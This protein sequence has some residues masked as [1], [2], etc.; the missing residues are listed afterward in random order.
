MEL[1]VNMT[2]VINC[3]RCGTATTV[4]MNGPRAGFFETGWRALFSM[5]E[6]TTLICDR[7][8]SESAKFSLDRRKAYL[9]H[10][11]EAQRRFSE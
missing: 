6:Q 5:N 3:V 8:L 2:T 7:C 1:E 9:N 4:D 11:L 10:M